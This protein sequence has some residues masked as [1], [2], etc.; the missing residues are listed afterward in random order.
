MRSLHERP[1]RRAGSGGFGGRVAAVVSAP[2]LPVNRCTRAAQPCA[3]ARALGQRPVATA[4]SSAET[5]HQQI[6]DSFYLRRA[7]ERRVSAQ[8]TCEVAD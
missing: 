6:R 8:Q 2:G 4:S 3:H 5:I 7:R 1:A